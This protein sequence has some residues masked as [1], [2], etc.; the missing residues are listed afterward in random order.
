MIIGASLS[1]FEGS[2]LQESMKLYL[3]LTEKFDIKAVEIPFEMEQESKELADFL[4]NFAI[5][6]AHLPYAG[7]DLLS[8]DHRISNESV[9]RLKKAIAR[10]AKLN[11]SYAVMHA[12]SFS[13]GLNPDERLDKWK[14]VLIE[15]A[16][17]ARDCSII[18]TVENGSSLGNLKELTDIVKEVNSK[19]LKLTLDIGHAHIRRIRR[20]NHLLPYP[21]DG[22]VLKVLDGTPLPFYSAR[23]MP[24]EKYG[25]MKNF[26]DAELDLVYNLHIHDYNGWRDHLTLK[27]GK[28]DFSFLSL[29]S[30]LP[31]IIEAQFKNHYRDFKR[32]YERLM[33]LVERG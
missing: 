30:G 4:A 10:A 28:I 23:Y 18:L 25:T 15:L 6:G 24:Y 16:D 11:M 5:T 20:T 1:S 8:P 17:Y 13:Y 9:Q 7:L 29:V 12:D 22:L 27:K 26:L 31:L 19:W 14:Q 3:D 21:L 32:N 33:N 2:T